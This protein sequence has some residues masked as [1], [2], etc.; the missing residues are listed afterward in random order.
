[1]KLS[2]AIS[3]AVLSVIVA[4]MLISVGS[5]YEATY[6]SSGSVSVVSEN[7]LYSPAGVTV[8]ATVKASNYGY[9][10]AN[11]QYVNQSMIIPGSSNGIMR[12]SFPLNASALM[13]GSYPVRNVIMNVSLF[14]HIASYVFAVMVPLTL[15]GIKVL[16][17]LEN[18]TLLNVMSRGNGSYLLNTSFYDLVPGFLN[19]TNI[20]VLLGSTIIGNLTG[21]I[22]NGSHAT[23]S[24]VVNNV[25]N[26]EGPVN[27]T[28]KAGVFSW[29][30]DSQLDW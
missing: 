6:G 19:M 2:S 22:Q 14:L 12:I 1:M 3:I 16:A 9:L 21:I 13:N 4:I 20:S 11:L 26:A 27:L 23:A 10:P 8:D 30:V 24:F 17:P 15:K 28:F 7:V 18:F 5:M 29:Q 25:K